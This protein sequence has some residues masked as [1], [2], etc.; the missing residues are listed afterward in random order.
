MRALYSVAVLNN[1]GEVKHRLE[2]EATFMSGDGWG[3]DNFIRQERLTDRSKG[4]AED[5]V[6]FEASVTVL[7][8]EAGSSWSSWKNLE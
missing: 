4:F 3:F 1:V 7:G 2:E 6:I 8:Q 5:V